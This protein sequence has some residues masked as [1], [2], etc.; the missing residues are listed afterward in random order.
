MT[1]RSRACTSPERMKV[2]GA[3]MYTLAHNPH[4]AA[5]RFGLKAVAFSAVRA[6][7][8]NLGL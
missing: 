2:S 5:E 1:H 8:F 3:S 6:H 4:R 7:R